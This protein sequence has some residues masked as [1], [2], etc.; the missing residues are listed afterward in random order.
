VPNEAD[1]TG[2]A[3]EVSPRISVAGGEGA[4][5][6]AEKFSVAVFEFFCSRE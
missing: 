6:P 5:D 2:V 4:E 3:V 1:A